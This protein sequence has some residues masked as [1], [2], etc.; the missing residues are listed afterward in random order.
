MPRFQSRT[1]IVEAHRYQGTTAEMPTSFAGAIRPSRTG[2]EAMVRSGDEI[3]PCFPGD[4]LVRGQSGRI[5]I[6]SNGEFEQRYEMMPAQEVASGYVSGVTA[7][8][9]G[10]PRGNPDE[11]PAYVDWLGLRFP[12]GK[13]VPVNDPLHIERLKLNEQFVVHDP[14]D[15][16]TP[17]EPVAVSGKGGTLT[18]NRKG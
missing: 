10:N 9:R 7:E 1:Y 11:Q 6:V 14:A 13:P 4:W 17:P 16:E 2:T 18:L 3:R 12:R 15:D 5:D 8:F